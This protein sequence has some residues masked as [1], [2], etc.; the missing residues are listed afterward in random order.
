MLKKQRSA[1]SYLR[2]GVGFKPSAAVFLMICA[3]FLSTASPSR[4]QSGSCAG[5]CLRVSNQSAPP[6]GGI[7]LSVV[8]TE[9]KPIV[10]GGTAVAFD[11]GLLDSVQGVAVFSP[12]GD[13]IGAAV[14]DGNQVRL[15]FTSP[16]GALGTS[17]DTPILTVSLAVRPDAT[18]GGTA[19]LRLDPDASFW[20][21]LF[22]QMYPQEVKPGV[23]TVQAVD[24]ISIK[25]VVLGREDLPAGST[26][27]VKGTGFQPRTR[28]VISEV[29]ILSTTFVSPTQ[30]DVVLAELALMRGKR[31]R[32]ENPDRSFAYYYAYLRAIP[33]GQ[34]ARALLAATVPIF[35]QDTFP[36]VFFDASVDSSQFLG[37]AFQNQNANSTTITVELFSAA[38]E[39]LGTTT[40]D[41]PP[42]T[43]IAREVSEFIT[44]AAP[45]PGSYLH[46]TATLPVQ[47]IG[48]IGDETAGSVAAVSPRAT[49]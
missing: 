31:V 8:V 18:P 34:S 13:V 41:L 7:Q 39:L 38:D 6:G 19:G 45:P 2:M 5:I 42:G 1:P 3:F 33:Q 10:T 9:P 43:R 22:G 12:A 27:T 29:R 35:A 25:E 23:F 21:D 44:S 36:E 4:A 49:R 17:L 26:I 15:Q 47:T 28:I 32:A 24:S 37:L 40:F 20:L 46:A 48:L 14:I 11:V 30:I 16:Q